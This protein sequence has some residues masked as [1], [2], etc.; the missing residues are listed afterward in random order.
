MYTL[1]Q[2]AHERIIWAEH[3]GIL[4]ADEY[5]PNEIAAIVAEQEIISM[6]SPKGTVCFDIDDIVLEG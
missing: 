6:C 4:D 1:T 3:K 5:S 2:D